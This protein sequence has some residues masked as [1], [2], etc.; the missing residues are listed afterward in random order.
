MEADNQTSYRNT[1]QHEIKKRNPLLN[2]NG[3]LTTCGYAKSLILDYNPENIRLYPLRF[4]NRARLK[5]WDYYGITTQD[6]FFSATVSNIGYIGL[7]F[8]YFIDFTSKKMIE[9]SVVTPFGR[10][11]ALP[12][13]SE[14]GDVIFTSKRAKVS[15]LREKET[16]TV[17]VEWDKFDGGD[18]LS[19]NLVLHQP[20][21]M[22]TI[23]MVTPIARKRF[24][25]NQKINCMPVEGKIKIGKRIFE[26]KKKGALGTLDWGRGVWEYRTFWN[27]A[28]ASGF[29]RDG[30][31]IGLNL[32]CGFGDLSKATENCFFIDG[33]MTKLG[34]VRFNY[35]SSDYK[36]PWKFSSDDNRLELLFE[37]FFE[38]VAKIDLLVL[39]SEVHQVFGKY[40]GY[41]IANDNEKIEVSE[42]IGWA[43]EHKAR[44]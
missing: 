17:I 13:T 34:A 12:K 4:L 2:E 38:R 27:W 9:R 31:T 35:D 19:A 14:S 44:W 18:R 41:L 32:G 10:G 6:F 26:L 24:Y 11:C 36:K 22:D 16:R 1:I 20:A 3:E 40:S 28:S 8:V 29:L 42:L 43:E 23:V 33:K 21:G 30:R 5:E 37:P 15:F 7:V 39:K 25:Y